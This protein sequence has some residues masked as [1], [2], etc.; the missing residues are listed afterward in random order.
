LKKSEEL[1]IEDA[2]ADIADTLRENVSVGNISFNAEYDVIDEDE[3]KL[4]KKLNQN[5]LN[6]KSIINNENL[7]KN[8]Q[9]TRKV[10][11]CYSMSDFGKA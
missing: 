11:M 3:A 10:P 8:N 1:S 4:S 7:L 9:I 2:D 6:R 5:N